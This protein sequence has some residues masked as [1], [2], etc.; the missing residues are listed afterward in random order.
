MQT[1][2]ATDFVHTLLRCGLT[3]TELLGDLAE[4]LE[5]AGAYPGEEP[6]QVVIEMASGSVAVRLRRVPDQEFDAA[7]ALMERAVEAVLADLRTAAEI[8][9]R[10]QDGHRAPAA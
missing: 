4:Q 2:S 10:R 6:G 1:T 8:A 9:R 5:D 7:A 3:L